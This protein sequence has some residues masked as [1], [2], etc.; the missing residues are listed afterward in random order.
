MGL[1]VLVEVPLLCVF[2]LFFLHFFAVSAGFDGM[3][4]TCRESPA[5]GKVVNSADRSAQKTLRKQSPHL[6]LQSYSTTRVIERNGKAADLSGQAQE[7][8][9]R[10]AC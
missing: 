9:N 6:Y 3:R 4:F 2:S 7:N 1:D 5:A 8:E 10:F